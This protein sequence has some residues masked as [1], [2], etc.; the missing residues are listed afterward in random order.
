[1][2]LD[3]LK[4]IN[5]PRTATV[6]GLYHT[7]AGDIFLPGAGNAVFE[8][9][10]QLPSIQLIGSA[11][12]AGPVNQPGV[13]RRYFQT[14]QP[15]QVFINKTAPIAGVGGVIAGQLI[16]QPLSVPDTSNGSE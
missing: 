16:H 11:I 12:Y 13:T 2:F 1:M 5:R 6:P 14:I 9:L 4:P 8:P 15:P 3:F 7:H 10:F